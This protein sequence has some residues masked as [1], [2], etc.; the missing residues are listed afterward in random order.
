ML[1]YRVIGLIYTLTCP[2]ACRDC[3]N[4]S[5][6]KA[7]GKMEPAVASE[8]LRTIAQYS[9]GVCF[10]GGEPLLYYNE[11]LPLIR[12]AKA[13]GLVVTLVTGA[14]WVRVNKAHIARERIF[15]LKDAGLDAL[16]ISWD[17]YHEEFSPP[18]NALLLIDLAK[19]AGLDRHVR[20][21]KPATGA[22]AR[23][24]STLVSI[25]MK[26]ETNSTIRLGT[27]TSLPDDHFS[28]VADVP[29]GACEI[30]RSP[31]IEPDGTVYACC[32]PARGAERSSALVLGNTNSESLDTILHR[33]SRDPILEA[34][35]II[36]PYGLLQLAKDDPTL[37]SIMPRRDRYSSMCEACLDLNDVPAIVEKL[38]A[39]LTTEDARNLL[40]AAKLFRHAPPELRAMHSTTTM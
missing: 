35:S 29:P 37:Q 7:K 39:R 28:F 1:D 23:I 24:E 32:G 12:E 14:G 34:I 6:P 40:V 31:T 4:S 36:G 20:G 18:E 8:Y 38:R 26:Y 10:T 15:A 2:L 27:A 17:V 21:V 11:V 16:F 33:G 30:V 13:L 22:V 25:G 5:S 19:E 9:K 3:I